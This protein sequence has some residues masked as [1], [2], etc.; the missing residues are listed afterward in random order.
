[1]QPRQPQLQPNPNPFIS[2]NKIKQA[3]HHKQQRQSNLMSHHHDHRFHSVNKEDINA[4]Y[5]YI[6]INYIKFVVLRDYI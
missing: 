3:F 1:M 6:S 4:I 2:F 5:I